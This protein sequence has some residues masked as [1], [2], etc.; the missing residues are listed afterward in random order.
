MSAA[1]WMRAAS[2]VALL[3]TAGHAWLF[4]KAKPA[5]GPAEVEVVELMRARAFSFGGAVRSY[6][7]FYWGYGLM[8]IL[9][10]AVQGVLFWLLAKAMTRDPRGLRPVAALY[11]VAYVGH[12]LLA[13]RY[14]FITPVIPDV[15]VSAC[16][17]LA[18]VFAGRPGA[19]R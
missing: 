18:V 4:L 17:L 11:L 13:W 10:C 7:D 3:Q 5:H 12:A 15:I 19:V 6:W 2:V 1:M 14:F 8:V 16:L 9:T